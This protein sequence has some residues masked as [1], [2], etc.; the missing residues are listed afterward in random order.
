M[1]Y[2][3]PVV[4]A[5]PVKHKITPNAEVQFKKIKKSRKIMSRMWNIQIAPVYG[6]I[7]AEVL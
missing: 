5:K 2:I 1:N 3:L 7:F 6:K 4:S